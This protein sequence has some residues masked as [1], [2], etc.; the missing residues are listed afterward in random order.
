MAI[1]D[2]AS[3]RKAVLLVAARKVY[4]AAREEHARRPLRREEIAG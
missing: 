1:S 4:S 3:L 2:E